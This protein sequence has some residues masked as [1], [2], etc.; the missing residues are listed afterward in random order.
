M[1]KA[2]L[3][4]ILGWFMTKWQDFNTAYQLRR[5]QQRWIAGVSD[6]G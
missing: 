4:V 2:M 1:N 3:S 6:C 5:M